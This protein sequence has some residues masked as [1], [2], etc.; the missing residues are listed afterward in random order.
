MK[1]RAFNSGYVAMMNTVGNL[2]TQRRAVIWLVLLLL[3]ALAWAIVVQQSRMMG[4]VNQGE[5][6]ISMAGMAAM[7]AGSL[8]THPTHV[9]IL[10]FL[11]VWVIMMVAMMFPAIVPV[12]SQFDAIR[13][14]RRTTGQQTASTWVLLIGYLVVWGLI[15]I[16]VYLLS[17][18]VPALG[19]MTAGLRMHYPVVAGLLLIFAGLYQLSPLKHAYLGYCR[20]P[21]DV[22]LHHWYDGTVGTFR[23]GIEQGVYCLACSW[24]LMLVLFVVGMMNLLAMAILTA[25]IFIE[26]V[27]PK[28]QAFSKLAGLALIVFG[29]TTLLMP[30]LY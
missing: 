12:V 13:Q 18:L 24:G 15:G 25:V 26:K 17:L 29:L 23:M 14:N 21:Q 8:G 1:L 27:I 19:M 4:S 10:F 7:N 2:F 9:S 3:T 30:I 11:P 22:F 6:G 28:G 20:C 5:P 16:G